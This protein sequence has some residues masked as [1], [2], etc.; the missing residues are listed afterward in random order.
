MVANA[1]RAWIGLLTAYFA[2]A[3]A[4]GEAWHLV[5]GNDHGHLGSGHWSQGRRLSPC[6]DL[7]RGQYSYVSGGAST[8]PTRQASA[9]FC[10]ICQ[11]LAKARI[12]VQVAILPESLPLTGALSSAVPRISWTASVA[13]GGIRGPPRA[14]RIT[15]VI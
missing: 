8:V 5:P 14:D 12:S 2:V 3:T 1:S 15:D 6:D 13:T 4:V 7:D 11:F 9:D 10:P